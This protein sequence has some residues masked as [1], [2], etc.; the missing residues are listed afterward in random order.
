MIGRGPLPVA[1]LAAF[2]VLVPGGAPGDTPAPNRVDAL[3][4]LVD[5]TDLA[6]V[7]PSDLTATSTDYQLYLK[8]L[9]EYRMKQEANRVIECVLLSITL[10]VSLASVLGVLLWRS[11]HSTAQV[12]NASG[13]VLVVFATVFIVVLADAEQQLTAAMGIL[14]AIVGYLFGSM[15]RPGPDAPSQPPSSP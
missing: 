2:L 8:L 3:M 14:G 9:H 5:A 11:P 10:V 12:L 7:P 13:L 15:R 1:V 6:G 4:K